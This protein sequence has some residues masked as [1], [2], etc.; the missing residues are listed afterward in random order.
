[1]LFVDGRCMAPV[2]DG[3]VQVD[4]VVRVDGVVQVDGTV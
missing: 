4:G 2:A 1:M 3:V